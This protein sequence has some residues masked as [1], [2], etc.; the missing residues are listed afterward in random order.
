LL[1][2]DLGSTEV[3]RY[4][5]GASVEVESEEL[6]IKGT[7]RVYKDFDVENVFED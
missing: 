7:M 2:Y 6:W 1:K 5:G 3:G 4:A